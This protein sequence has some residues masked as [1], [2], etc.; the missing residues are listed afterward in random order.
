[1]FGFPTIKK[2]VKV[3]EK[4][5]KKQGTVVKTKQS[6]AQLQEIEAQLQ[7]LVYNNPVWK[8]KGGLVSKIEALE[9]NA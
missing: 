3:A 5:I 4:D 7:G 8:K 1:M 2:I 9:K 6:D